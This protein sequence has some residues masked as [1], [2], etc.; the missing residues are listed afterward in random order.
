MLGDGDGAGAREAQGTV[1]A[2][3]AMAGQDGGADQ[4]DYD[5]DANC[6]SWPET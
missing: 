3:V 6:A 2:Q 5:Y 4:G 1:D